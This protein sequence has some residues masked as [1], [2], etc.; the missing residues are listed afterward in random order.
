MKTFASKHTHIIEI[1]VI[2]LLFVTG[3]FASGCFTTTAHAQEGEIIRE[4]YSIEDIQELLNSS[5][6]LD[7]TEFLSVYSQDG[8]M[9]DIE[10]DIEEEYSSSSLIEP[11]A[12][13]SFDVQTLVN[14]G[15]PDSE[16]IVITIMGDG[17]TSTG[18]STFITAATNSATSLIS[19]YPMC[20][21]KDYFNIY[22]VEVISEE[23]GVSRD[24]S[25]ADYDW[26]SNNPS[27]NNYF[28]SRFYGDSS[29]FSNGT[30]RALTIKNKSRARELTRPNNALTVII[31]NSLRWGGTGGEFAV[32]SLH[33]GYEN[34]VA[35]EFGH[36]FGKLGDE[37]WY[38]GESF[39]AREKANKSKS[40]IK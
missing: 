14:S 10:V 23:S 4:G 16:S 21:F 37:Y 20:L 8:T 36:S 15:R 13:P 18:Q 6:S 40:T 22:A 34:I 31:C 33:I 24:I 7:T 28:G 32:S 11:L 2:I 19:E 17:F 5:N 26:W 35:H 27:V 9:I 3:I 25:S 29:M 30:E 38:S 1:I 39:N 12:A